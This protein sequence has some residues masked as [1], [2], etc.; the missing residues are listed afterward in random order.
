M[1][2]R[3]QKAGSQNSTLEGYACVCSSRNQKKAGC[4]TG[5]LMQG[6]IVKGIA[7]FYYIHVVV[8]M[9]VRQK[10]LSEERRSGLLWEIM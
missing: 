10:G 3:D 1:I 9:N 2:R 6:K 5:Q 4:Q 7:G 8:F